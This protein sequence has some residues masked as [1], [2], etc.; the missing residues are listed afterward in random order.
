M[1]ESSPETTRSRRESSSRIVRDRTSSENSSA[2]SPPREA[3]AARIRVTGSLERTVD[4]GTG[5]PCTAIGV[6]YNT[7]CFFL[8]GGTDEIPRRDG[9]PGPHSF[10]RPGGGLPRARP[11]GEHPVPVP[12]LRALPR[13]VSR[14]P[15]RETG[16]RAGVVPEG[17]QVRG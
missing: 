8:S 15:G 6:V 9:G 12:G 13:R 11:L 1:P 14:L 10:C 3:S 4:A 17:P 7:T 2:Y 16:R 5:H